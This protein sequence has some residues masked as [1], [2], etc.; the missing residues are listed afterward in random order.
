M[1]HIRIDKNKAMNSILIIDV[2][3]RL[4]RGGIR[5]FRLWNIEKIF[6]KL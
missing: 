4:Q 3:P 5:I 6:N 1:S 2:L